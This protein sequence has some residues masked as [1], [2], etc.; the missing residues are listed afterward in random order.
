MT[1]LSEKLALKT[2]WSDTHVFVFNTNISVE[3]SAESTIWP[4]ASLE[5]LMPDGYMNSLGQ[6]VPWENIKVGQFFIKIKS[7]NITKGIKQSD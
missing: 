6:Y 5:S 1:P 2:P 3:S 4:N 7:G